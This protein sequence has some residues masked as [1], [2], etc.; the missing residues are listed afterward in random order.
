MSLRC[1]RLPYVHQLLCLQHLSSESAGS[2]SL[3]VVPIIH[4]Y[5][6]NSYFQQTACGKLNRGKRDNL[7][8]AS[9]FEIS[10]NNFQFVLAR[11]TYLL[12]LTIIGRDGCIC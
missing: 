1:C 2:V 4:T 12:L 10:S 6:S 7:E 3:S 11:T 8:F 5:S 9:W